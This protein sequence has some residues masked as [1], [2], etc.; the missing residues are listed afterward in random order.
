MWLELKAQSKNL[1]DGECA[2]VRCRVRSEPLLQLGQHLLRSLTYP[3]LYFRTVNILNVLILQRHSLHVRR[4]E[5]PCASSLFAFCFLGGT[6]KEGYGVL[7]PA[8]CWSVVNNQTF[9][10][11]ACVCVYMKVYSKFYSCERYVTQFKK[12]NKI[13]NL[14]KQISYSQFLLT[15][16]WT[17]F[18]ELLLKL[19]SPYSH[20]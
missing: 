13:Y 19:L 15:E 20:Y 14:F 6:A 2:N 7:T 4:N 10:K 8:E 5:A 3:G 12:K 1:E 11:Y 16:C 18:A 9:G 17:G